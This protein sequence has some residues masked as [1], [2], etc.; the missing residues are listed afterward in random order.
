MELKK[1]I[2][3]VLREQE[4]LISGSIPVDIKIA[5]GNIL[6]RS[7]HIQELDKKNNYIKGITLQEQYIHIREERP[8]IY[9]IFQIHEIKELYCSELDLHYLEDSFPAFS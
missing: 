9:C 1:V 3:A 4:R 2:E 6:L 8:P 5:N 7:F